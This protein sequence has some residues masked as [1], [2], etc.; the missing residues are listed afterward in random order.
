MPHATMPTMR[1]T[2]KST[3][4]SAYCV[5]FVLVSIYVWLNTENS[6]AFRTDLKQLLLNELV[7]INPAPLGAKVDV[8]YVLGGSPKSLELKYKTA[9]KLYH[10]G[11]SNKIWILS[12]PGI[13]EYSPK[14]GRNLTNDEW[15]LIQLKKLGV[16]EKNVEA[17]KIEEGFFGTFSEAKGISSLVRGRGYMDI[18]LITSP[19]HTIRSKISFDNFL[20][21]RN[22]LIYVQ[23]SGEKVLLRNLIVEFIKLKAYQYFLLKNTYL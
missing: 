11:I 4:F 7:Y 23:A 20:K 5:L 16:P 18:V 6:S 22:T 13:T 9:A 15:S 21:N 14:S 1:L 17:V 3:Y 19:D 10:Q 8:V 2:S 12:R